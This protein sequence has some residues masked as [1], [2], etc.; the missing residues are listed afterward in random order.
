METVEV[1]VLHYYG[2]PVLYPFMT[3]AIF[4]ILQ[5][6]YMK[7]QMIATVPKSEFDVMIHSYLDMLKN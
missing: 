5:E 6:A 2:H 7:K 4:E 3:V 1:V